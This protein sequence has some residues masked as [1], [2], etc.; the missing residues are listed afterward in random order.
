M[1]IIN[2]NYS[3]EKKK[4]ENILKNK[5][6]DYLNK[7]IFVFV[8]NFTDF[9]NLIFLN[10]LSNFLLNKTNKNNNILIIYQNIYEDDYLLKQEILYKELL[11]LIKIKYSEIEYILYE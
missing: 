3:I 1:K 5:K 9:L 8:Y 11:K 10:D 2:E 6:I 7:E 4:L